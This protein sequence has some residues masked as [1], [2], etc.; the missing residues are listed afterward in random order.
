[1][2]DIDIRRA[3]E[4]DIA[5]I[6]AMLTDDAIGSTRESPDDLSAYRS[7]FAAID[8]DPS[9]FLAVAERDGEIVGTLQLSFLPGMS[10]GGALRAQIE[11]VRVAGTARG[12][13]LGGTLIRWAVDEARR[14]GCV[15][16]Q[17]TSDKKRSDAHRFYDRL[18]FEATHEGYKL[19]L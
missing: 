2:T 17:L 5:P 16:V 9:E 1:M 3:V 10:R 18:G 12:Q 19:A 7:A 4:A 8:S 6:V 15:L 13:G 11:G 14:R